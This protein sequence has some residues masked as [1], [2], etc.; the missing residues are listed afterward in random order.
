MENLLKRLQE[1]ADLTEEQATNA[2]RVVIDFMEK[3]G[4]DIDWD[5]FLSGKYGKFKEQSQSFFGD[6]SK[7]AKQYT[8]TFSDKTEDL[9]TDAK[10]KIRDIAQGLD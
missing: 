7:K 9:I 1:E 6:L 4:L 5:K 10:R 3:E 2:L 8:N